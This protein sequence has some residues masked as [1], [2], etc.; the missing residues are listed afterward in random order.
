MHKTGEGRKALATANQLTPY[1]SSRL[2]S[3]KER[4][5]EQ[6]HVPEIYERLDLGFRRPPG[7][8]SR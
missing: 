3:G 2:Q 7:T 6:G 4:G 1:S 5:E 8:R